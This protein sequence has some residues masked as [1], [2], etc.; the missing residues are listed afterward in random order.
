MG[1]NLIYRYDSYREGSSRI[2]AKCWNAWKLQSKFTK[3][4]TLLK[5]P[6][7]QNLTVPVTTAKVREEKPPHQLTLRRA[8]PESA[9]K[10]MQDI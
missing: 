7:G 3:V 6:T 4:A 10:I 1:K 5:I 2:H 9:S 8:A